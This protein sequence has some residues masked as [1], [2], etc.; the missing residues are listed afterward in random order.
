MSEPK[1][2]LTLEEVSKRLEHLGRLLNTANPGHG[3]YMG[4]ELWGTHRVCGRLFLK[5][6]NHDGP[7]WCWAFCG[8]PELLELLIHIEEDPKFIEFGQPAGKKGK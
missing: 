8:E 3:W 2:V 6:L 4:L 7:W 5:L 1:R